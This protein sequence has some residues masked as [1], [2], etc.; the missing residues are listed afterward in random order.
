METTI[1]LSHVP[2]SIVIPGRAEARVEIERVAVLE[3]LR[4]ANPSHRI[5]PWGT[6]VS[7]SKNSALE[8]D[9]GEQM[10]QTEILQQLV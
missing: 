9:V 2:L 5:S 10:C 4:G 8:F 3:V 6:N 7:Q 1:F